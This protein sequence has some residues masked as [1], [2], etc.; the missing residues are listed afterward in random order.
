MHKPT[1]LL[2]LTAGCWLPTPVASAAERFE[3]IT[4]PLK[5][6][7]GDL[8]NRD[9]RVYSIPVECGGAS[10]LFT[11]ACGGETIVSQAFAVRAGLR[12]K[13]DPDNAGFMD[14]R[15]QPL[16][17][18]SAQADLKI[19][20]RSHPVSVWVMRD[21]EH[22]KE[23]TGI[24]GYQVA[25]NYQWEIDPRVP[26]LTLRPPGTKPDKKP[27]ASL[28]LKEENQNFWINLKLRN[29]PVDL[30]LIPQSTDLQA[31]PALQKKWDLDHGGL[32]IET[33]SYLGN[34]RTV[35]LSGKSGAYFTP[36]IFETEILCILVDENPNAPSGVG[37]SLLNRF[38]Y[39]VD[40]QL[41]QFN[42]LAR[43]TL[44]EARATT[45]PKEK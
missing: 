3:P 21:G 45:Q 26:Q 10:T 35:T 41:K 42:I 29:V 43:V 6:T 38:V 23:M 14:G 7:E 13:P 19:V 2:L 17:A 28:P 5:V 31:G 9:A 44:K 34:V 40:P 12:I 37:Q 32:K 11:W 39:S 8:F 36:E 4:L 30:C 20:G 15:G 1:L 22:N 27:L 16:F 24:I 18:G 25:R 33:K